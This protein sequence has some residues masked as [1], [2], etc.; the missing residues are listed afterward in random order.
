MSQIS[1]RG[2]RSGPAALLGGRRVHPDGRVE[3]GEGVRQ[4]VVQE[5]V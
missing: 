4:L 1:D 2:K 3:D 5:L